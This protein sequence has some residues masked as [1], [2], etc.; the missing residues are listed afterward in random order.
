[1]ISTHGERSHP[2]LRVDFYAGKEPIGPNAY[3]LNSRPG[4]QEQCAKRVMEHIL[5]ANKNGAKTIIEVAQLETVRTNSNR[6]AKAQLL[7]IPI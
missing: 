3:L 4:E 2:G 6:G 1:M 7:A 5:A